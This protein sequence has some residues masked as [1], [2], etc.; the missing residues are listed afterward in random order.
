MQF[1]A[2]PDGTPLWVSDA[3]PGSTVDIAAARLHCLPALYAAAAHGVPT[4][5]DAGYQSAGIGVHHPIKKPH[6]TS[7]QHLHPDNR[8]YNALLH[9]IRALGERTAAE[10]KARWRALGASPSAPAAPATSPEPH[11]SSTESGSDHH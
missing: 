2:A 10:L 8:T 4:L 6:G 1:L 7:H 3:E 11:S 9:G 5:T